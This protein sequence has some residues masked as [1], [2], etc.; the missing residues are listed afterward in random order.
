MNTKQKEITKA[1]EDNLEWEVRL[2]L[3]DETILTI[4][5]NSEIKKMKEEWKEWLLG[6]KNFQ[7]RVF[8]GWNGIVLMRK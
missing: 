2:V 6:G 8:R 1:I 5:T 3:V 7:W 4:G